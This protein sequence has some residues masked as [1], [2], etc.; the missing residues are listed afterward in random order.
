MHRDGI[1]NQQDKLLS[2]FSGMRIPFEEFVKLPAWTTLPLLIQLA[3][4]H[5]RRAE[6]Q[7]IPEREVEETPPK[8]PPRLPAMEDHHPA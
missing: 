1:M 8:S 7:P 2:E 6:E 3:V 4:L 5:L